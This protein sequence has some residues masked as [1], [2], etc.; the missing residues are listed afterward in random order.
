MSGLEFAR[1]VDGLRAVAGLADDLMAHVFQRL[2][3]VQPD[4]RLV[5]RDHDAQ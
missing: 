3:Q 2:A 4:D 5:V 1:Q